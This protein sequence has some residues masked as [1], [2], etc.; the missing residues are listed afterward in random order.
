MGA[1]ALGLVALLTFATSSLANENPILSLPSNIN[2]S[3]LHNVAA[4]GLKDGHLR[5]VI[6]VEPQGRGPEG[7]RYRI[8]LD[9][10]AWDAESLLG[11]AANEAGL[12][13]TAR[14]VD[15]IGNDL[16]LIIK[17]ARSFTPVGVW[18]NN[19]HGGFIK[20]DAGVYAPSIWSEVP[21]LFSANPTDTFQRAILPWHQ[22]CVRPPTQ[23]FQAER[24]TRQGLVERA[25]LDVLSRLS[26][27]PQQTRGPPLPFFINS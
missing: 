21:L 26:T 24:R 25:D 6:L 12:L 4:V 19:H 3:P 11:L 2:M 14:D 7:F 10:A 8:V 20:A 1:G 13:V 5:D 9:S 15:G 18:I 27:E 22:S 23:R 16:D 17:T